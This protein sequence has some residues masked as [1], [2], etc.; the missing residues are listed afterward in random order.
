MRSVK[1]NN[2]KVVLE[3][4]K[5]SG[6]LTIANISDAVRIS[7]PTVQ[8][9][10][11]FFVSENLV[12]AVGKGLSA[13][14]GGKKPSLFS[15]NRAHGY[16]ISIYIGAD[17]MTSV[18]SDM[19]ADIIHSEEVRLDKNGKIDVV[20]R[21]VADVIGRFQDH[22]SIQGIPLIGIAV[23]LPG[24]A[25]PI[26]GLM[27]FSPHYPGWETDFPI[28]SELLKHVQLKVPLYFDCVN[29]FQALAER[30]K[31][32]AQGKDNFVIVDALQEGLGAGFIVKGEIKHG[33]HN[34]SGEIGHMILDPDGAPCICGGRGCFEAMVSEKRVL[35]QAREGF[36][37]HP[38][39]LIFR[40][41]TPESVGREHLFDAFRKGDTFAKE[42]V[43]DVI[44]W[45]AYGLINVIMVVDPELIILQGIYSE[46]GDYFLDGLRDRIARSSLP[47]I[48]KNVQ[49]VYS[50]FGPE[51][52]VVGG[53]AYV[54]DTYFD[55][56][57]W[58]KLRAADALDIDNQA[59]AE[60]PA[61]IVT[62]R[63]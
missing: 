43:D 54:C 7:T 10:V 20:V 15:F 38:D 52:G 41:R 53:A 50:R 5:K 25:D 62:T 9:I 30:D 22:S 19:N 12:T 57:I 37:S 42:I 51:R 35:K 44:Q 29:R 40:S 47:A 46:L 16:T 2:R 8:K 61:S 17:T 45:F 24:V 14:G 11:D 59:G 58:K 13:D 31:G 1:Q 4:M 48:R 60:A 18:I 32:L 39:S 63:I 56:D 6:S 33:A 49:I 55:H 3:F 26:R 34:L 23:A 27:V 21:L 28:R 36:T